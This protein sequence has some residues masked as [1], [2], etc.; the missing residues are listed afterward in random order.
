MSTDQPNLVKEPDGPG[1]VAGSMPGRTGAVPVDVE[2][3]GGST[4]GG[5]VTAGG[6]ADDLDDL[7]EQVAAQGQTL[8]SYGRRINALEMSRP[9]TSAWRWLALTVIWASI[10]AVLVVALV[11]TRGSTKEAA[12]LIDSLA[13]TLGLGGVVATFFIVR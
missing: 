3:E 11:I 13:L 4:R 2:Y 9:G 10:A 12:E 6:L 1:P 7:E 5:D 8:N